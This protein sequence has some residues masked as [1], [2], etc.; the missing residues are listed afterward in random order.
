MTIAVSTDGNL[1]DCKELNFGSFTD[2]EF[3]TTPQLKCD[4]IF[5]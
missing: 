5:R 1:C 2:N 3:D 4:T